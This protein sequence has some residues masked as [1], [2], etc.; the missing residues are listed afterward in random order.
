MLNQAARNTQDV[1][2]DEQFL[3][4]FEIQVLQK[5]L[6]AFEEASRFA[7][8]RGLRCSVELI[9]NADGHPE[10]SL[11]ATQRDDLPDSCYRL[12]A[13]PATQ[14]IAHE[15]FTAVN[16]RTRRQG[17][18]LASLTSRALELQLEAFFMHAFGMRL[19]YNVLRLDYSYE[20]ASG[21]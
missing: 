20:H 7:R 19:D 9:T 6:P 18:R 8:D 1:A 15:E 3:L 4:A 12:I 10:L 21:Q 16:R 5:A 14:G 11:C 2:F 17:A 13:D